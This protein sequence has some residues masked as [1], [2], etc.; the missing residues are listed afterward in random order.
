MM[1]GISAETAI[2]AT[3]DIFNGGGEMGQLMRSLD[4]SNTPL[5]PRESWPQSLRTTISICLSS[6]FPMLIWWGPELV[7]LYN[8]AYRPILGDTKHPQAMGQRG[9]ECWPEIWD[10][11]GPMLQDV[12]NTGSATWSDNQ[13]LPLERNGYPEEC[14]FTFSYSPIRDETGGIGGVFTAVTETTRQVLSERRLHTLHELAEYSADAKTAEET[15]FISAGI[16]AHNAADIPFAL[17]YLLEN[18]GKKAHLAGSFGLANNSS[19]CPLDVDLINEQAS[20]LQWPLALVA[21]TR[22]TELMESLPICFDSSAIHT[23][24]TLPNRVLV[25]PVSR[26]D[27]LTPYGILV[28]GISPMRALDDD[29]RNFF[30]LV[31]EQIATAIGKANAYHEANLRAEAL[32]EIDRAKTAFFSNVSH[33]FRTP[34]TLMLGPIE[35]ALADTENSLSPRQHERLQIVRRNSLR[36]LKLVNTLLDFSRIEAGRTE[37]IYEPTDLAAFTTDLASVFRSAME[38]AALQFVVECSPLPELV[39]IDR[40]MWEKIVLNLLSNAFKF[41]FAG[42]ITVSLH[43]ED[44]AAHLRVRDTGTGISQEELPH[45]FERFHRIRGAKARTHEGSGIGLALVNELVKLHNGN[46]HVESVLGEGTTFTII[47]PLGSAHLPSDRIGTTRTEQSTAIGA[48]PFIEDA[49]RWLPNNDKRTTDELVHESQSLEQAVSYIN[50][51][52]QASQ[53][54]QDATET[55]SAY[56]LLADDNADMRDYVQ[57]LLSTHYSVQAVSNGAIALAAAFERKPDL[58]ISDLMMPELDGFQLLHALRSDARTQAVP[59]ILLSARAGEEAAIEGLEAGADDYLVKPFS[60]RELLARIKSHLEIAR[61]REEATLRI[62]QHTDRLQ[63]LA[64]AALTINSTL[65]SEEI[66]WL[67]TDKARAIIG[68]HQGITSR[69]PQGNWTRAINAVSLSNTYASWR[70]AE[71][72]IDG[73]GIYGVVFNNNKSVRLSQAELERHAAWLGFS[74]EAQER[75]PMRGW[76]AAPLIGRNGQNLGLIQLS[77]KYDRSDFTAEDEAILIQIAQ[78]ASV[79]IENAHLYQQA[80]DAIYGRDELLSLVSHDL[81]NPVGTIKGY[82][83]LLSRMVKRTEVLNTDQLIHGLAK[84]DETSTK[85]TQLINELLSMARLQM[86][87]HLDLDPQPTDIIALVQQ[88]VAAQQQTTGRHKLLVHSNL[89]TLVGQWD[90]AHLERVFANLL[91]NAI[92]YSPHSDDILLEISQQEVDNVPHAVIAIQDHGIG[93]PA[94]D[95]PYIFEQFHRAGNVTRSITGT[96]IGLSSVHQIIE[97]HGGTITVESTEGQGSLFTVWLP[98]SSS[99]E[100]TPNGDCE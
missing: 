21:Q 80:Q 16:L 17:L 56:I 87:Q 31:A 5:G 23:A 97:Q 69:V 95:L 57:R 59:V 37:A 79:A 78:M 51:P 12:I 46:M 61:M 10:I 15:C 30:A 68:A 82:A 64:N 93:I 35:D 53:A 63:K 49:L 33:E 99:K 88:V 96:G 44:N 98:L 48:A 26:P 71:I 83:Q 24:S 19:S 54:S 14:Y 43:L 81:K 4:W 85:M 38:Q 100:P 7:M 60:A 1:D 25:L 45:L 47:I 77:D 92:K 58:V 29:Y 11:I 72:H 67:I 75:P 3:S 9:Q 86:G 13:M 20:N 6:R 36:L 91:S 66:L 90:I 50:L 74:K 89:P 73:S 22:Q 94:A 8:D 2:S 28:A 39:Y 52:P 55:L 42:Q 70:D 18:D 27:Q 41:T 84:I 65:S 76:L 32:A 62:Q 34:L 40:D